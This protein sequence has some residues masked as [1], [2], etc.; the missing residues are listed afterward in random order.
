[1]SNYIYEK[2][3]PYHEA[4]FWQSRVQGDLVQRTEFHKNILILVIGIG[5]KRQ[6]SNPKIKLTCISYSANPWSDYIH[7]R[8]EYFLVPD[9]ETHSAPEVKGLELINHFPEIKACEWKMEH[10]TMIM[11][12]TKL[13]NLKHRVRA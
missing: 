1:M 12:W 5:K 10:H 4:A 11:A 9:R 13:A 7:T 6:Y 8:T 2:D 3:L